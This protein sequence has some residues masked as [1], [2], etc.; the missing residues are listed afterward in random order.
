MITYA[1]VFAVVLNGPQLIYEYAVECAFIS[2]F[3]WLMFTCSVYRG[4]LIGSKRCL[5]VFSVDLTVKVVEW[6]V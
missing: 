1:A 5:R 3:D 4:Q 6:N 2:V